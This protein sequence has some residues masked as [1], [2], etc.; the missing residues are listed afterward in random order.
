MFTLSK[1][2]APISTSGVEAYNKEALDDEIRRLIIAN[3]Q[4]IIDKI[5]IEKV[6]VNLKINKTRLFNEKN[7]LIVKK[8]EF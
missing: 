8:E 1:G 4:L 7:S 6:K 5:K 3:V 2:K